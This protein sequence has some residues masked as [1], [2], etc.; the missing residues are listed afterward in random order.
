MGGGNPN[1]CIGTQIGERKHLWGPWH[2]KR[3]LD[4]DGERFTHSGPMRTIRVCKRRNCHTIE[5]KMSKREE[6]EYVKPW[7]KQGMR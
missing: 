7:R 2:K 5:T 4:F 6:A 3:E 1:I